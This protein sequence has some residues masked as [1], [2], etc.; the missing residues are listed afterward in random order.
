VL[1]TI[2]FLAALLAACALSLGAGEAGDASP[3]LARVRAL[4]SYALMQRYFYVPATRSLNGTYPPVG[5]RHAQVWPYSQAL[6]A[7]LELAQLPGGGAAAR[8]ALPRM[9]STL[10]AYRAPI[11]QLAY[12]PLYGGKG[13]AFYDDNAW[14]GIDLVEAAALLH[15]EADLDAA[16]RVLAWM[17]S[18][19]DAKARVCPGGVYWLMPGGRYWNRSPRARY[20]TAVSTANGA[21]LAVLLYE[22]THRRGDLAWAEKA[23]AWTAACLGSGDGLIADHIDAAGHVTADIHSYNQGAMVATAVD[24][25]RVTRRRAYL[26]NALRIADASLAA[27]QNPF[28]SGEEAS[29]L[30]IYYGDLLTLTPIARSGEI[31]RAVTSFADRA[32]AEERDPATGLFQFG[33]TLATLLDQSAMVQLYAEL[34]RAG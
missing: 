21:L 4:E 8:G 29:M 12:A 34:A 25:Y 3:A 23:Y 10:A 24:L 26:A 5:R 32:W 11:R 28:D 33:H 6:S 16:Q 18:G 7:T 2:S 20:R 13:N 27:F 1:R 30:S 14:I 31:R 15:D 9:I 19:W 22:Q 17:E